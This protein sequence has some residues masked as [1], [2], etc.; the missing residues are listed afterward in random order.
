ML[1]TRRPRR[2]ASSAQAKIAK[3]IPRRGGWAIGGLT[4]GLAGQGS[5]VS[6]SGVAIGAAAAGIVAVGGLAVGVYSDGD[7]GTSSGIKR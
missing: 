1:N 7:P 6:R 5:A 2:E 3:Q 4:V